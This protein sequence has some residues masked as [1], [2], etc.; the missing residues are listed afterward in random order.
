MIYKQIIPFL[1]G[2]YY[3]LI[4]INITSNLDQLESNGGIYKPSELVSFTITYNGSAYGVV[5]PVVKLALH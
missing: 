3:N 1:Y 4:S 2:D 5:P